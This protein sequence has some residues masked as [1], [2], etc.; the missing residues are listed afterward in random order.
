MVERPAP[1]GARNG[2]SAEQEMFAQATEVC[3]CTN[4]RK[5]SRAVT[6]YFDD[7]LQ[8]SGVRST[9]LV[10]LLEVAVADSA[11][12]TR[13]ARRLVMDPSTL[14]RNLKPLVKQGWLECVTSNRKQVFRLT[15]EGQSVL[16]RA[17]PLWE[18]AQSR[19]VDK[20]GSARWRS[21]LSGLSAAVS[22]ARGAHHR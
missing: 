17:V 4:F 20:L 12:V 15:R 19:F 14:T 21:L 2:R 16:E 18:R 3:A 13:L 11:T 8:P 5:A 1:H 9:Q 7:V 22:A 6:Q 10:V